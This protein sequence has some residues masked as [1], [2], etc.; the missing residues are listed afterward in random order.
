MHEE[1]PLQ[2]TADLE[3]AAKVQHSRCTRRS[4]GRDYRGP[5]RHSSVAGILKSRRFT[6]AGT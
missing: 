3:L 6:D 1:D 2:E 4:S 5:H